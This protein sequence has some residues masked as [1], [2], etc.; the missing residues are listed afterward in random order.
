MREGGRARETKTENVPFLEERTICTKGREE[1]F[2]EPKA[3]RKGDF[4]L[5][6]VARRS[7]VETRRLKRNVWCLFV[8][9]WAGD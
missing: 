7:I 2:A 3:T 9:V 6:I 5:G 4:Q 1:S 8:R